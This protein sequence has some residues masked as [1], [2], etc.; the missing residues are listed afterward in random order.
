[1]LVAMSLRARVE[2]WGRRVV[3]RAVHGPWSVE[4]RLSRYEPASTLELPAHHRPV[5][6]FRAIDIHNHLG[7]WL[8]GDGS[9]AAPDV[10]GVLRAMDRCNLGAI[11]NLDGR[12]GTELEDNLDR[13][14]RAHPGRFA[15]FCHVDWSA[16]GRDD[17]DDLPRQ[18]AESVERGA[19]GLKVWKDLGRSVRDAAGRLL[20]PDDPRLAG[21]WRAAADAGIPVIVHTADPVAH[22]RPV[23]RRNER[24]EELRRS[25]GASWARPGLPT[26]GA[27][28][29]S[30]E[31]LVRA[32]PDTTFIGAHLAGW[33]ENLAKVGAMLADCP[34][35]LVDL[36]AR[37]G[38]L[39][40]Q[41]RAARRLITAHPDRV[42]FGSDVYPLR[43]DELAIYF[44]C[45]ETDDECFAYSV[46]QP[47]PRGRWEIS[48]LALDDPTLRKVYASNAQRLLPGLG[49]G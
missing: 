13:Y 19:R 38:D 43:P 6:R 28:M 25:P 8:S 3:Q 2:G 39:G 21:L 30:F 7:R 23:D 5:A 11:V 9:W 20:L 16:C 29:E 45:L 46:E 49:D 35:L 27:L 12:W 41:P 14:D 31:A 37:V 17:F 34:N 24:L 47:P 33:S 1:M 48:G 40:R 26:H 10:D 22:F 4:P 44:R 18:L 36:S 32:N 15:T 42:L